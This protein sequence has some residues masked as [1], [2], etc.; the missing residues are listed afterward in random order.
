MMYSGELHPVRYRFSGRRHV[1]ADA[2]RLDAMLEASRRATETCTAGARA[3]LAAE[4]TCS[5]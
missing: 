2:D 4:R 5:R 3:A 1:V